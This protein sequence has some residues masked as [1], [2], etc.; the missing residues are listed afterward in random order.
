V[1]LEMSL[2]PAGLEFDDDGNP[3][4]E[5]DFDAGLDAYMEPELVQTI[6]KDNL[7]HC[8]ILA[9]NIDRYAFSLFVTEERNLGIGARVAKAGDFVCVLFGGKIPFLLRPAGVYCTFMEGCYVNG[10]I[11]GE[12]IKE[13]E[14]GKLVEKCFEIR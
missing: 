11:R 9:W 6:M 8:V 10:I 4:H 2:L 7:D 13:M 3:I 1:L 12:A 14:A 5:F